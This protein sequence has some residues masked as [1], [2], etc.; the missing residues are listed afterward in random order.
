MLRS[1]VV[2]VVIVQQ[3]FCY[4]QLSR[5]RKSATA[6]GLSH[7]KLRRMAL[8]V[9]QMLYGVWCHSTLRIDVWYAMTIWLSVCSHALAIRRHLPYGITQ[10]YLPPDANE[11]TPPNPRQ[12]GRYSTHLPQRDGR[13]SWPMWLGTYRDGL[14][15]SKQSPIQ[16][17]IGPDV[18]H[19]CWSRPCLDRLDPLH[20][21]STVILILSILT[22]QTK[23]HNHRVLWAILPPTFII[24]HDNIATGSEE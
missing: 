3:L 2:V 24:R 1:A 14:S 5:L 4:R 6:A 10:C 21:L 9:E 18:Q 8:T 16:V 19:L 15:V 13:L 20:S 23:D 7:C 17:I 12:T 22:G 11:H